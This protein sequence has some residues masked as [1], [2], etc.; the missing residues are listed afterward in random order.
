M[1]IVEYCKHLDRAVALGFIPLTPKQF[2]AQVARIK[3]SGK[4]STSFKQ[5]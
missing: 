2:D 5:D 1:N 4:W 3:A